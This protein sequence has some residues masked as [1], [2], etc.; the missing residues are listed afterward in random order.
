MTCLYTAPIQMYNYTR[1][2]AIKMDRG[3]IGFVSLW[4]KLQGYTAMLP[5][6][7]GKNPFCL[8]CRFPGFKSGWWFQPTPLK[9]DG[10]KVS[11]DDDIPNWMEKKTCSKPPTSHMCLLCL[12]LWAMDTNGWVIFEITVATRSPFRPVV[13]IFQCHMWFFGR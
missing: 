3:L 1:S 8:G 11:W 5:L 7:S 10:V 6:G 12:P 4:A 13:E 2:D 9:N